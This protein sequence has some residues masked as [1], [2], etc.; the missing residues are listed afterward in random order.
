[1]VKSSAL[2]HYLLCGFT[3]DSPMT[4]GLHKGQLWAPTYVLDVLTE[5]IQELVSQC[6]L[7]VVD[8][9]PVEELREEING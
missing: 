2:L 6:M 7:V 1:M 5:Y 8:L 9:V 4:I 3:T